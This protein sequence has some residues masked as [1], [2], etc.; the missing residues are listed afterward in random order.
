ML[1]HI[2]MLMADEW[3]ELYRK[4]GAPRQAKKKRFVSRKVIAALFSI[5]LIIIA[6]FLA[7]SNYSAINMSSGGSASSGSPVQEQ[8]NILFSNISQNN[9]EQQASQIKISTCSEQS[10]FVC[11]RN[12]CEGIEINSSNYPS[13][14]DANALICCS[15]RCPDETIDVSPGGFNLYDLFSIDS[16]KVY[17][18]GPSWV[19]P[20]IDEYIEGA[21]AFNTLVYIPSNTS[22]RVYLVAAPPENIPE[23]RYD[24]KITYYKNGIQQHKVVRYNVRNKVQKD[25]IIGFLGINQKDS[26][27]TF[28]E[29][30][31]NTLKGLT[32]NNLKF[33]LVY[34]GNIKN[35][36]ISPLFE[37]GGNYYEQISVL[38]PFMEKSY[39]AILI[40]NNYTSSQYT[41]VIDDQRIIVLNYANMN[42]NFAFGF[43]HEFDH[44]I[45]I[46]FDLCLQEIGTA[47]VRCLYGILPPDPI[48]YAYER[49]NNKFS[50]P[51]LRTA[52]LPASDRGV[53]VFVEK[54]GLRKVE[55][56]KTIAYNIWIRNTGNN[57]DTYDLNVF[58]DFPFSQMKWSDGESLNKS[59][60]LKA[61]ETKNMELMIDVPENVRKGTYTLYVQAI[62]EEDTLR[63]H[64]N[65]PTRPTLS[66]WGLYETTM[67]A[68]TSFG[69]FKVV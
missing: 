9:Q 67:I 48:F 59:I 47:D 69:Y 30:I 18:E 36:S 27:E 66:P 39:D 7:I 51:V 55:I 63:Y 44:F 4:W 68:D 32:N 20:N 62:S 25:L 35:E 33:N 19:Y 65:R 24:L 23:G 8:A 3:D 12:I 57:E 6:F 14:S 17:F 29:T 34:L 16:G 22:N 21:D 37:R 52:G 1:I 42:N 46:P 60:K 64:L 10:G 54:W 15:V 49:I 53:W 26:F 11:M 45:A 58:S 38:K 2:F 50:N 28:G 61:K 40:L 5:L 43:S 41:G 31:T 13:R 56:G